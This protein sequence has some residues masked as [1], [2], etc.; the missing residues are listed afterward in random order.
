M[1]ESD[2]G[3]KNTVDGNSRQRILFIHLLLLFLLLFI[4]SPILGI[5]LEDHR[6]TGD[7][8]A[9]VS[10]CAGIPILVSLLLR[11]RPT[12]N[13][14]GF[15]V[16]ALLVNV[17][18]IVVVF[19]TQFLGESSLLETVGIY[20]DL[21]GI[22]GLFTWLDITARIPAPQP[23]SFVSDG[24]WSLLLMLT[25][26]SG[27]C[28]P[29]ITGGDIIT[30]VVL[31]AVVEIGF[32]FLYAWGIMKVWTIRNQGLS[33]EVFTARHESQ[34]ALR[35][36][37]TGL[38]RTSLALFFVG[39]L[40]ISNFT[41]NTLTTI[42]QDSLTQYMSVFYPVMVAFYVIAGVLV[43]FFARLGYL[44]RKSESAWSAIPRKGR[45]FVLTYLI[46]VGAGMGIGYGIYVL[47]GLIPLIWV[48]FV[49]QMG[50]F[51]V[52]FTLLLTVTDRFQ[53]I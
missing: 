9:I 38:Y 5:L 23:I 21:A 10:I 25:L 45:F 19:G 44:S 40:L 52:V 14:V 43:I 37:A 18:A 53:C 29:V 41:L 1:S 51:G 31:L 11:W 20:F 50:L 28:A 39:V 4:V 3:E 32:G 27:L 12:W 48:T 16:L 49:A 34:V 15:Y 42:L 22:V 6:T 13:P 17:I 7:Y 36:F 47:S 46:I 26:C 24:R 2:P 33:P 30:N 8:I 35:W